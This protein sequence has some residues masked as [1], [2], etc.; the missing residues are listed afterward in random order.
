MNNNHWTE[1]EVMLLKKEYKKPIPDL[2]KL[3]K[4]I[5]RL[6]SNICRKARELGL[7]TSYCRKKSKESVI[8]QK[9]TKGWPALEENRLKKVYNDFT[10]KELAIIFN[11]TEVSIE[12][13]LKYL[14]L[15]KDYERRGW[16]YR[17]GHPKGM[18]GKHHSEKMKK[19]IS[20]SARRSWADPNNQLNSIEHRQ[21][22]SDRTVK[23][24]K[25]GTLR[26]GYSRGKMGT[27]EDLGIYV[28]SSWEANFARYL[29]WM[30]AEGSIKKWE[31]EADTF[32]F[33]IKRGVRSY[34]PDFK[35]WENDGSII[36]YEV[37]GWM[38]QR[39][40]TAIK[41]FR[42][43]YP[44][45]TLILIEKKEYNAISKW[46]SLFLNWE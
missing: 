34:M 1:E 46:K 35:V 23:M 9:E 30:K 22:L 4:K 40:A 36:Y 2:I 27:R 38:T 10:N 29:N 25:N 12:K 37:K 32:D 21:L 5:N 42:K 16:K 45:Q 17:N 11:K 8:K 20:D 33:P 44:E 24:I 31:Y 7:G 15:K 39:G 13:K 28:R 43:Y 18:L 19:I 14:N 3:S 41:R 6:R 26:S